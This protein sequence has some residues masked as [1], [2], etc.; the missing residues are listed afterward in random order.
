QPALTSKPAT[1]L[2][3]NGWPLTVVASCNAFTDDASRLLVP[4]QI[5]TSLS[6][7]PWYK[8]QFEDGKIGWVK[9]TNVKE[10]TD[11]YYRL[12]YEAY[13][14]KDFSTA[15]KYYQNAVAV[16]QSFVKGYFWLA[17]SYDA[18]GD[19]DSASAA[20]LQ[21]AQLDD[22]DIEV[23]VMTNYL[24]QKYFTAAHGKYRDGRFN[25]AVAGYRRAID[26][27]PDS[28]YSWTEMGQSL[29]QLGMAAEAN[30][31]WKEALK[32]DPANPRL[33]TLLDLK[34]PGVEVAS[35]PRKAPSVAPLVAD[36]SLQILKTG[37]TGKGTKIEAAIKS[38]ISLTKSLG[39]P[40]SEKGWQV[41]KLGG[42]SLVSYICEQSG[43]VLES[44][45]WLVDV[46]TRQVMP[47]ND[48]ARILMTRW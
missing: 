8:V 18:Q 35:A 24:A 1:D 14:K 3:T 28:A 39:T 30:S 33:I 23:K 22:R 5:L 9:A 26:L 43:G 7:M 20:I 42:K 48:N 44:F 12:G 2:K 37:K 47:H 19:L 11:D 17:K 46:D 38:V 29:W 21:A 16:N 41:K 27:K 15:V 45:E 36:D 4:G 6:K 10:P 34:A 31:A 32:Y 25:E 13:R 40:I